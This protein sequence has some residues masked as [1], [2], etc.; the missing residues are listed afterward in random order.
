MRSA[1]VYVES[2]RHERS[3]ARDRELNCEHRPT[4]NAIAVGLYVPT[5]RL[6]KALGDMQSQSHASVFS[7][8][9]ALL[10][11]LEH[12]RQ[13]CGV[14]AFAVVVNLNAH[15]TSVSLHVHTHTPRSWSEFDG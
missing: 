6:D 12:A 8:G 11:P 2:G 5:V 14:D 13:E 1:D 9:R 15:G 3:M 10:E 7:R 4:S